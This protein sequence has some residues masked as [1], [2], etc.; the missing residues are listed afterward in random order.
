ME[1]ATISSLPLVPL[2]PR[3]SRVGS[4]ART[5]ASSRTMGSPTAAIIGTPTPRPRRPGR[6]RVPSSSV[7]SG[8]AS[9]IGVRLAIEAPE[10][11]DARQDL[12]LAIVQAILDVDREDVGA[13]GRAHAEGDGHGVRALV[14]DGDRDA[15]HA[16][17]LGAT[18]GAVVETDA[19]LAGRQADDLDLPPA[20][21]ADAEP[22][23]LADGLLGGPAAGHG[24]GTAAHVGGFR[25]GQHPARE[26]GAE[27]LQRGP[28]A[29]DVD[30][31]DAQLGRPVGHRGERGHGA[32]RR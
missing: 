25:V 31:V 19:G 13:T 16:E 3:G 18:L 14:A 21:A 23:D 10:S 8:P 4:R 32:T 24:L 22:E 27:A 6:R 20:D 15:A 28:D 17:L 29:L 11:L 26:A 9:G 12:P 1:P 2:W 30:D 5:M 7:G